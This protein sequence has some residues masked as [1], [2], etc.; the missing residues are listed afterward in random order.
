MGRGLRGERVVAAG[1]EMTRAGGV[2]LS[3]NVGTP[4]RIERKGRPATS[5]IWKSPVAGR[6]TARGVNLEGD[7]QAD[8]KVHGGPDKAIYVYATED[9]R[10]WEQELGR[11]I[12]AG[13][14]GE[15]L[16]TE[17]IDLNSAVI[18]ERWD[19]G[20]GVFEVSEPRLPCWKLAVRMG[21][22]V[23]ARRFLDA[24]R[25][26]TYLRIIEEGDVGAGDEIRVIDRP[27]HELTVGEV[28]HIYHTARVEAGR[29]LQAPQVSES[30][31]D[32]A[33]KQLQPPERQAA[34]VVEPGCC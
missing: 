2:V 7:D 31:R 13:G 25:T 30:W 26:G 19:I 6:V 28:A 23:F 5:A 33:N 8:R 3:V 32:W 16:T 4:R 20:S 15:N 34:E 10:W 11:P 24:G 14:F 27:D 22:P 12:E 1:V 18:G 29:L 17:G 21:D 9:A